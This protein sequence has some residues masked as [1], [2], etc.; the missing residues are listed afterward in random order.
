MRAILQFG[1]DAEAVVDLLTIVLVVVCWLVSEPLTLWLER[2]A[3]KWKRRV[4][5]YAASAAFCSCHASSNASSSV[6]LYPAP[7]SVLSRRNLPANWSFNRTP[8]GIRAG[9]RRRA[10][11]G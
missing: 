11:A 5:G 1:D 3:G 9:R 4:I 7:M 8:G 10:G 6:G 2:L